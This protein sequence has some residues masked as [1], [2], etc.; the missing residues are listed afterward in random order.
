MLK[1]FMNKLGI[2]EN[3]IGKEIG[4]LFGGKLM[5]PFST[6]LVGNELQDGMLVTVFDQNGV[7]GAWKYNLCGFYFLETNNKDNKM[8]IYNII[9]IL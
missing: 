7:I 8:N 3:Y 6:N 4:F 2:S 9:H 5:N 1:L